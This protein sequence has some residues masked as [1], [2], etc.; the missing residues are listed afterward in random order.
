MKYAFLLAGFVLGV[1]IK[2]ALPLD[3]EV[4]VGRSEF[5]AP[6]TGIWWWDQFGF[7]GNLRVP[8]FEIG[9]RHRM[10]DFSIHGAYLDLGTATGLN[11]AGMRDDEFGKYNTSRPCDTNLQKN[12]LGYFST[13]QHVV[14]VLLGGAYGR[15]F[16]GVHLEGEV[17]QYLYMTEMN[18]GIWCPN[19]GIGSKY[20]FGGGGTFSSTSDIRRSPYIAVKAAYKNA[21]ITYRRFSNINGDGGSLNGIEEQF[22]IGLTSGPVNQ[23]MVGVTL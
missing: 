21:F 16:K 6:Q 4:A 12:C 3:L 9:A 1:F 22:S 11:V 14:G 19:C 23:I 7:N 2:G 10:G 8:S 13:S 17:G 20:A 15:S 18:V 5:T